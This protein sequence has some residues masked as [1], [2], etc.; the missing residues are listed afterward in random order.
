MRVE[1]CMRA[2]RHH[3]GVCVHARTA[4][5][6]HTTSSSPPTTTTPHTHATRRLSHAPPLPPPLLSFALLCFLLLSTQA[7]PISSLAPTAP[8]SPYPI[9]WPQPS[10]APT[11]Y[12]ASAARPP[13]ATALRVRALAPPTLR[14][15]C[16]AALSLTP[17]P[18]LLLCHTALHV[19][20]LLLA[21]RCGRG[22]EQ[23]AAR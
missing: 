16:N 22:A 18:L 21:H 23:A 10:Q 15:L 14:T 13:L 17:P 2:H 8:P 5:P 9:H 11:R 12:L 1:L 3:S 19:C 7:S 6:Q 4:T 20:V